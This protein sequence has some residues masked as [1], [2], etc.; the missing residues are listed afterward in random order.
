MWWEKQKVDRP[1]ESVSYQPSQRLKL[2]LV[3]GAIFLIILQI[4]IW[5]ML[6]AR[7]Y[8]SLTHVEPANV[9]KQEAEPDH[10]SDLWA[11]CNVV[12]VVYTW[13]NGRCFTTV[14][15]CIQNV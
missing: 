9:N 3:V 1:D 4:G 14:F 2:F 13:V 6:S 5:R 7:Y 15:E 11:T 10:D 12:D 8:A